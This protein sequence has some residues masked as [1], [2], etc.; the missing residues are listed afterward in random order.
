MDVTSHHVMAKGGEGAGYC[1]FPDSIVSLGEERGDTWKPSLAFLQGVLLSWWVDG[2]ALG[3]GEGAGGRWGV[4][5][6]VYSC[7]AIYLSMFEKLW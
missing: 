1:I 3:G 2:G 5:P 7:H 6:R 4:I